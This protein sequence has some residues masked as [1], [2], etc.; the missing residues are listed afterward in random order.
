VWQVVNEHARAASSFLVV[1]NP[2]VLPR[3]FRVERVFL[4]WLVRAGASPPIGHLGDLSFSGAPHYFFPQR[5]A[6]LADD[7]LEGLTLQVG[8]AVRIPSEALA[9]NT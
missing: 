2:A 6:L 1:A 5:K 9:Q 8:C 3:N 4:K 7:V